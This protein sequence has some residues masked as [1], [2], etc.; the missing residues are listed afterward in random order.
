MERSGVVGV[1]V[2]SWRMGCRVG[3]EAWD[4][5]SWRV[6]LEGVKSGLKKKTIKE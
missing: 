5:E 3:E 6:D 4:V 2:S 1:R